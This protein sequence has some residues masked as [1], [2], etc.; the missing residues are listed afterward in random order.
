MG[1][2]LLKN[3][4]CQPLKNVEDILARQNSVTELVETEHIRYDLGDALEQIYD[5]QRLATRMSNGSASP[6]DFVDLKLSFEYAAKVIGYY[7][8]SYI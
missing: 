3:W 6:K 7:R 4:I 8:K 2:R 1:A 5:I